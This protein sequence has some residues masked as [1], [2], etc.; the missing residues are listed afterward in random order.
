MTWRAG[1]KPWLALCNDAKHEF[2]SVKMWQ[3][4]QCS[5]SSLETFTELSYALDCEPAGHCC[6]GFFSLC[7]LQPCARASLITSEIGQVFT[8]R[9]VTVESGLL[10]SSASQL[11]LAQQAE[12]AK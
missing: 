1:D 4:S 11:L 5:G 6:L 2:V 3:G 12:E 9:A 7:S 10:G 8:V